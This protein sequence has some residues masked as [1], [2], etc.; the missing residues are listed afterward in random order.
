MPETEKVRHIMRG[1]K[2]QLFAGLVQNPPT[3][4]D[5]F[6]KEATII[7]RA[8]QQQSR[9]FQRLSNNT[10]MNATVY[11][12]P[13]LAKAHSQNNVVGVTNGGCSFLRVSSRFCHGNLTS[14]AVAILSIA[15]AV[16]RNTP[17]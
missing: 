12:P 15:H 11:N 17:A 5:E 6:I 4:I 7:E 2:E 8:V 1:T 10:L 9:L 13:A 16:P 3:T 14:R